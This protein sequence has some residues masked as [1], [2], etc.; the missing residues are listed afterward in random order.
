M[1]KTVRHLKILKHLERHTMFLDRKTQHKDLIS[2]ELIY[3]SN[4]ISIKVPLIIFPG[5]T[6]VDY[7]VY[8]ERKKASKNHE[9]HLD[10]IAPGISALYYGRG[11]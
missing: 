4:H 10:K 8:L 5:V 6:E 9:E 3:K 7:I 1:R 11:E 2:L